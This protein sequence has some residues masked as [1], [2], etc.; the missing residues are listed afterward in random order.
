MDHLEPSERYQ[1][2]AHIQRLHTVPYWD[3]KTS[4]GL[5]NPLALLRALGDPQD[6]LETIHVTGTNGKGSV[7]NYLATMICAAGLKSA[8][9]SSPHLVDVTERF[10]VNGEAVSHQ[11][12]DNALRTVFEAAQEQQLTPSFF[13]LVTAAGFLIFCAEGVDIAVI[14]VGLGGRLDATNCIAR[15]L[16]SVITSIGL[17]HTQMLGDTEQKIAYEK[18]G[19]IKPGRPVVLGQM[20]EVAREEIKK[21][22]Q[23]SGSEVYAYGEEFL[24]AGE[25]K[26]LFWGNVRKGE[27]KQ[28]NRADV[29]FNRLPGYQ[30]LNAAVAVRVA[31]LLGLS[32]VAIAEGIN[33]ARW[34]GRLEHF[35]VS[36]AAEQQV[37]ILIDCAHNPQGLTA[38]M[39]YLEDV[40]A[41]QQYRSVT[42]IISFLSTKN[43]RQMI[44][45]LS[46]VSQ[47]FSTEVNF[48]FT[49][50]GHVSAVNP[51]ELVAA[52]GQG[53]FEAD[54]VKALRESIDSCGQGD[55]LVL[56]GSMYLIGG[57]RAHLL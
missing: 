18:A 31:L 37:D 51:E 52:M 32:K 45:M 14:E 38:L 15:P 19:I 48:V 55:L 56:T 46:S 25:R 22:A 43:W 41:K 40:V 34:P 3:G 5:D 27:V 8:Q 21:A 13:E 9:F 2:F 24:V 16:L 1:G 6:A 49:R 4:F 44:E 28:L 29:G 23:Q 50:S 17:D 36:N 53:R 47:L 39:G 30:P 26:E 12:L 20:S 42:F 57:L 33:K 35:S 10:L 54:G 11:L 7:S